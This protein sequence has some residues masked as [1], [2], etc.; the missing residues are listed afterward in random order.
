[1]PRIQG[2]HLLFA[3]AL[4]LLVCLGT[5]WTVFLGRAVANERAAGEAELQHA[6]HLA[7]LLIGHGE[8]PDDMAVLPG[9]VSLELLPC[10]EREA[11]DLS[12]AAMPRHAQLCVRPAPDQVQAL[13]EKLARR[14]LMVAGEG[15]LLFAAVGVIWLMLLRLVRQERRHRD[16]MESFIHAVTHEMKTPLAGIMTLLETALSGR[17]PPD[18]QARLFTMGLKEAERLEHG[19]ENVLLAGRIRSGHHRVD[20]QDLDL[21]EQLDVFAEH[22]RR[23]LLDRPDAL[24]I[25]CDRD[26]ALRVKADPDM[27]RVVLENLVDNGFKYGGS[28]AR[29]TVR[30]GSNG[31]K[32]EIA[33]EDR[34]VGFDP[35]RSEDLFQPFRRGMN[36]G[37]GATHGTGLGLSIA[38]ALC[39]DMG[40]E[41]TA[42]SEGAGCGARFLVTLRRSA[43]GA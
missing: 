26:A 34:G 21:L 20:L 42:H 14:R 5:W 4:A 1:M 40:G 15:T 8:P 24:E 37:H 18:S 33:V 3:F 25:L 27:L 11:G 28:E 22:R 9:D 31:A 38:R 36:E 6:A 17:I 39:R 16:R 30:A 29:V 35:G 32:V 2:Y 12:V 19:I 23:T 41:L 43:E 13:D 10:A 7:A